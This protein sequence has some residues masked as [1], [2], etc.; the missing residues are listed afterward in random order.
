MVFLTTHSTP[1]SGLLWNVPC[2]NGA[3]AVQEVSCLVSVSFGGIQSWHDSYSMWFC[4][5]TF[6]LLLVPTLAPYYF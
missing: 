5:H 6:C 3:V 4:L 2:G 1:D